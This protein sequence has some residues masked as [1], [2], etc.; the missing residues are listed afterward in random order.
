VEGAKLNKER[1]PLREI[2]SINVQENE[3]K[4]I[5]ANQLH[6]S[7]AFFLLFGVPA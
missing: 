7:F 6:C 2:R 5:P 4:F 1:N 3:C